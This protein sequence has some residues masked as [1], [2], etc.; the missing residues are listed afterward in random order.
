MTE[1]TDKEK[2]EKFDE[3]LMIMDDQLEALEKDAVRHGIRIDRNMESLEL[4]EQLFSK[5]KTETS[6]DD[7][8]RLIVY[9]ARYL[10]EIV[11]KTFGGHWYLP[12]EDKKNVN[13]NRPIVVGHSSIAD[14]EFAPISLARAY[15]IKE[16]TGM[17]RVA[18]EADVHPNPLD[19]SN[20]PDE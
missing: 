10:G 18:I 5:M 11:I 16:K 14:L 6:K 19:L 20:L 2:K 3:F 7:I 17:F 13:Y 4:L 15:S 1:T 9:F 8:G 12:L